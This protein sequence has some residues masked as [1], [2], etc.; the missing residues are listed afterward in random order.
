VKTSPARTDRLDSGRLVH[1]VDELGRRG[2]RDVVED[3]PLTVR[4]TVHECDANRL[5]AYLDQDSV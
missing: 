5:P 4:L 2:D 3:R 1:D